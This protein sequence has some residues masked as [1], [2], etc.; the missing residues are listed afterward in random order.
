MAHMGNWR[1]AYV[2]LVGG[3]G[4]KRSVGGTRSI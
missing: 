4:G 1:G 2:L 3:P